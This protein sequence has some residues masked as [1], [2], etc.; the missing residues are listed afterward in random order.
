MIVFLFPSFLYPSG[1]T[2]GKC[3]DFIAPL[4]P[5]FVL[6]DTISISNCERTVN[7]LTKNLPLAVLV[8]TSSLSHTR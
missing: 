1:I 3:P 7:I 6:S 5:N 4:S 8:L 2:P